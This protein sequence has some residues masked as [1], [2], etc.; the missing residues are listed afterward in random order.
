MTDTPKE[1]K[2]QPPSPG[3]QAVTEADSEASPQLALWRELSSARGEY[4]LRRAL[5]VEA[6]GV[7]YFDMSGR[8]ID[9]N[10]AFLAMSRYSRDELLAGDL[11]W[12]R[13][14]PPEWMPD[15][16][17]AFAELKARGETTPYEK[18][19]IRKDGSR[20]WALFAAKKLNED[21]A[22][23]FVINVS[24]RKIAEE[25]LGQ[26][27]RRLRSLIDAIPQLVWRSAARGNWTWASAQWLEYTQLTPESSMG[28]GW[29]DALHPD[30]RK[31]AM[32]GWGHAASDGAISFDCRIWNPGDTCYEWFQTRATPVEGDGE[33]LIEWVGTFTNINE[34]ILVR[35]A[36][37][38][39]QTELEQRVAERT[40]EL[41]QA[42]EA[43]NTEASDRR[44]AEEQL[45]QSE[46]LKAVGQLTG[47]I[48][49]DFNNLLAG[50]SGSLEVLHLRV[51]TGRTEGLE[52]Y[53]EM[54]LS[55][56]KRAAALT[57]RLLAFSRQQ[58][59]APRIIQP[60][61][62]VAELEDLIRRTVGPSI[63]LECRLGCEDTIL[64]DPGQL[65]NAVV[66]LAINARDAMPGGGNLV[67]EISHHVI[68][69]ELALLR[70]LPPGDYI[71]VSV[72]DNGEGMAPD[73]AARAFD[74]FFTTKNI[75]EGT[76]LGLSMVYG[77][78][79]QSGGQA[80]IHSKPG[81]GTTVTL[82]FPRQA[83]KETV[84]AGKPDTHE[85]HTSQGESILVVD[86]EHSVRE[87]M[88]E[89]LEDLGYQV[90]AA[91]DGADG[92]AQALSMES[93]DVLVTDV[94]LPGSMNGRDLA[95]KLRS[96]LPDLKVLFVTGF[97]ADKSLEQATR[98]PHTRLLTKP[99][100]LDELSRR[101]RLLLD[102]KHNLS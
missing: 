76:G 11:T 23:E 9:A 13:L 96:R 77:F 59:L 72:T 83:G 86:D 71:G 48:A 25:A 44:K 92:L 49:H 33:H 54:A 98:Q 41:Q 95:E 7:I 30:D 87:L 82:Y 94:G 62:T 99:F 52:R 88:V 45:L 90:I 58:S 37:R 6:I 12:Q 39:G 32:E 4:G 101:V 85:T 20:W 56:V 67:I 79:Q 51:S 46:K 40:I 78:T 53:S 73:V 24:E 57:H 102:Q 70:D 34:Q 21:L 50:I 31:V 36:L 29:L 69:G 26:S 18:Q 2:A 16:H 74:P 10:N 68:D 19:Y 27:E 65:E 84:I 93:L 66:N 60:A 55:S 38:R 91:V 35:E 43:L 63:H 8:I 15:S 81:L 97:A 28:L 3:I 1:D 75:S 100:S 5:D 64:C 22:F 89:V 80:R 47:G 61:R 42:V 17:R 14:T